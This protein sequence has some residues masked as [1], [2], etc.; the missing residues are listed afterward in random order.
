MNKTLKNLLINF[1]LVMGTLLFL[2][3]IT[4]ILFRVFYPQSDKSYVFDKLIGYRREPGAFI[5][6]TGNMITHKTVNSLGFV[7]TER[8][9]E[10]PA[11]VKRIVIMGDSMTEA[12]QV[13]N[14]N[15]FQSLLENELNQDN[16]RQWEVINLG[17]SGQNS[18][19][20]YLT[21][22]HYGLRF[23]PDSAIIVM[24]ITNDVSENSPSLYKESDRPYLLMR[25]NEEI[26]IPPQN[27]TYGFPI[28]MLRTY[29][30]SFRWAMNRV[31]DLKQQINR[32]FTREYASRTE[33]KSEEIPLFFAN[34]LAGK[35]DDWQEAWKI[36]AD[37]FNQIKMFAQQNGINLLVII[38]PD[39]TQV[40]QSDWEEQ[41]SKAK[42][43]FSALQ[44]KELI[45]DNEEPSRRARAMLATLDIPFIDFLEI[46]KARAA[47]GHYLYVRGDTHLN[48]DGHA[49][50]A[51]ELKAWVIANYSQ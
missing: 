6:R 47:E 44:N 9:F 1:A 51:R 19:Q 18:A 49:L 2:F 33:Q 4:E 21:F 7:D 10:K 28:D 27:P 37:I 48:R 46:F 35:N 25:N 16:N 22:K 23:N 15:D 32:A 12:L 41:L 42:K 39:R 45:F 13:T 36:T 43:E 5:K 26:I 20:E 8:S 24:A 29:F 50:V 30:H 34:F 14:E 11:G 40:Y 38:I 17:L 3:A 31:Y